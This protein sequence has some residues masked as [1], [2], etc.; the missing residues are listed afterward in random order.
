MTDDKKYCL[1]A[2]TEPYDGWNVYVTN[3]ANV[4]SHDLS[5]LLVRTTFLNELTCCSYHIESIP[6]MSV[7]VGVCFGS[8][9]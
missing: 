1:T 7:D 3:I 5:N 2:Q 6:D 4:W 9:K 8:T